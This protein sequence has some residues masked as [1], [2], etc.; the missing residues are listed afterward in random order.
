MPRPGDHAEAAPLLI[1][2]VT[3]HLELRVGELARIN[4]AE[5]DHVVFDQ[6]GHRFGETRDGAGEGLA[7]AGVVGAVVGLG[8]VPLL[9]EVRIGAGE[10]ARDVDRLIPDHLVLQIAVLPARVAVH[11]Q[12][13]DLGVEDRY[14]GVALVVLVIQ[15]A[16]LKV[17]HRRHFE[18]AQVVGF[19]GDFLLDGAVVG[20]D[21]DLFGIPA[22]GLLQRDVRLLVEQ[23]DPNGLAGLITGAADLHASG[24]DVALEGAVLHV[25]GNQLD[26]GGGFF[27][28]DRHRKDL[29]GVFLEAVQHRLRGGSGCFAG[30]GDDND[31][32][33]ALALQIVKHGHQ[34]RDHLR[35]LAIGRQGA[36]CLDQLG[37]DLDRGLFVAVR[38]FSGGLVERARRRTDGPGIL[39]ERIEPQG[40]DLCQ[41]L[42]QGLI[43]SAEHVDHCREARRVGRSYRLSCRARRGA[44]GALGRRAVAV[45]VADRHADAVVHQDRQ[46]RWLGDRPGQHEH[47]PI[48]QDKDVAE[49]Q[50]A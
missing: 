20:K 34:R 5:Q 29:R 23:A 49:Q 35:A 26:V 50:A 19:E 44:G 15:L 1:H 32:G 43:V 18:Q 24:D 11:V 33:E 38:G 7:G 3:D 30:V 31:P 14:L 47:G 6:L 45:H 2:E 25:D 27:G 41:P 16:G 22:V 17:G 36:D 13:I 39:V 42:E 10:Q 9:R 12:H 48:N 40:V 37:V 8:A 28:A 46:H 21:E 4:V